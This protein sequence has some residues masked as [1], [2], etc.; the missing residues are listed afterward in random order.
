MSKIHRGQLHTESK[1]PSHKNEI[2]TAKSHQ[3]DGV[4]KQ[5]ENIARENAVT[6][7]HKGVSTRYELQAE[8]KEQNQQLVAANVE[9]QKNLAETQQSLSNLEQKYSDLEKDN[10]EVQKNLKDCQ[11]TLV[12]AKIDPISG[13]L[14]GEAA[15]QKDEQRKEVMSVSTDLLKELKD[16]GDTATQQR[17]RLQEIQKTMTDLTEARGEMMQERQTFALE[18]A[19]LE[20][21]LMEAEAFLKL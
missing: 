1:K 9:L 6:K 15:R 2:N 3:K 16:F 21:A 14:I 10:W 8:L 19:D 7:T 11:M 18:A 4:L 5:K 12:T 17:S 13:E 20:K